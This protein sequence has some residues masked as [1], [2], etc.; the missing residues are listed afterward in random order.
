MNLITIIC[1]DCKKKGRKVPLYSLPEH[2]IPKGSIL[3]PVEV[4]EPRADA[5]K[6][7]E[8]GKSWELQKP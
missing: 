6:C 4:G 5:R 8:C 2:D 7:K 1:P 3:V